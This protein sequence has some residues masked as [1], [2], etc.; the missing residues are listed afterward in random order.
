[1]RAASDKGKVTV[2]GLVAKKPAGAKISAITAYDAPTARLV[3][4][5]GIDLILV[6]DS[7][8]N[9]VLGRPDTLS[10]TMEEMLHHCRAVTSSPRRA[11]VVGDMPFLS[12]HAGADEAIRN[13][14]RFLKEGG[15]SA[16]KLEG[17]RASIV[18]KIVKAE[19]PVMGHL[20]L[21]PQSVHRMGGYKVQGTSPEARERLLDAALRL[22]DA[23]AFALVLEGVPRDLAALLTRRLHIPTIGIGAGPDCD[24]QILVLHDL[25]GLSPDKPPKFVRRYA[26][27]YELSRT[28]VAAYVRD[29]EVGRFPSDAE[30]YH[31]PEKTVPAPSE[32]EPAKNE[33][34]L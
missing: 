1:M 4:D 33:D 18:K 9:A 19:I 6:G 30:S 11:L 15:A 8:G 27:L 21:T 26:S 34:W 20:G 7:V 12:Y 17:P 10:V 22:Q 29:V 14:G 23:G 31:G 25:L 16:V 13:A 32:L 5:A 3:D 2:P 24:G 28:A